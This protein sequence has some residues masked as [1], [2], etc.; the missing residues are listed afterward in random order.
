MGKYKSKAETNRVHCEYLSPQNHVFRSRKAVI[1]HMRKVGTYTEDDIRIVE[2]GNVKIKPKSVE[3][4][5]RK[6]VCWMESDS[7]PQGWKLKEEGEDGRKRSMFLSPEG[8]I[9]WTRFQVMEGMAK[10][11]KY[12]TQDFA[13]VREAMDESSQNS[14]KVSKLTTISKPCTLLPNTPSYLPQNFS[15]S[16]TPDNPSSGNISFT[17]TIS[18]NSRQSQLAFNQSQSSVVTQPSST[19]SSLPPASREIFSHG[20][21]SARVT[22]QANPNDRNE[23]LRGT[24]FINPETPSHPHTLPLPQARVTQAGR[25]TILQ[26]KQDKKSPN[27][28]KPRTSDVG[29]KTCNSTLPAGWKTRT[30]FW[31][32][33]EKHVF[34]SPEGKNFTSRKSVLAYMELA[35]KY[36]PEDFEK[37]RKTLHRKRKLNNQWVPSKRKTKK[38]STFANKSFNKIENH[39]TE[40]VKAR[41]DAALEPVE[42]LLKSDDENDETTVKVNNLSENS[43]SNDTE[44]ENSTE[45]RAGILNSIKPCVVN[46]ERL[47][48]GMEN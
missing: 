12:S 40:L 2:S 18:A 23:T 20:S 45:A 11:G 22:L 41:Q 9:F 28:S 36:S 14:T 30:H 6:N 32:D 5:I 13:K 1:E 47:Q 43:D 26:A 4:A 27:T 39:N 8:K 35:G 7:L 46:L 34:L 24:A 42:D 31:S 3:S 10:S 48:N 19:F 37:V 25:P 16:N 17:T 21:I 44:S 15:P 38:I 29:W 33:R